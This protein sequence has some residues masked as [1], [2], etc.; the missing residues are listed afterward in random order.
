MDFVVPVRRSGR[1]HFTLEQKHAILDEYE[2]C[3]E[4]GSRIAFCRAVGIGDNTVRLWVQQREAGELRSSI[5]QGN[6]DQRLN[7]GD[8]QQLKRVLKENE[9][10]KAKLARAEAAVDILGKASALLDAMAKSAA[11]TD[12]VLEEPEPGRPEWLVPKSGK[13]SP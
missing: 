12:P 3:L 6:E 10:L 1:S 9:I 7:A 4:R 8:K 11:A 13:T 2:K 5:K